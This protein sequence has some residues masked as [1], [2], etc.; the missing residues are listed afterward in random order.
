MTGLSTRADVFEVDISSMSPARFRSVLG[1]ERFEA[2]EQGILRARELLA[3]RVVW[4]VDST[5]R[6]GG[7]VNALQRHATV[8]AQKSLQLGEN[9]R[10][11][12]RDQFTSS[13][14]LLDYLGLIQRVVGRSR[15]R[16]A[17]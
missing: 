14:S 8:V 17:A 5:A 10:A 7:I 15:V 2:F 9:A 1:P 3:G 16:A 12:V 11:R 6:G 13:R 4:N